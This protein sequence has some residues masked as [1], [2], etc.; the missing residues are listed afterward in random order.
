MSIK[1]QKFGNAV[2]YGVQPNTLAADVAFSIHTAVDSAFFDIKYPDFEWYNF[3]QPDQVMSDVNAGATSYAYITRDKQ[4]SAAFIGN[5]P[6]DNIP[7]VAQ[8]IGA[9]QVPVAYSAVGAQVTNEDARQY[10][11]GF[12]GNLAQ[13]LGGAMRKACDNLVESTILFGTTAVKDMNPL[14]NYPGI[15]AQTVT[16]GTWATKD[17]VAIVTD[18]NN[19]LS[20]M[21]KNS[22]TLFKPTLVFVPLDQFGL[23][24]CTPMVIGGVGLAVTILEYVIK[25]NVMTRVTGKELQIIPSRYLYNASATQGPRMIVM[26][27][28]R[29]NQCLPFPMPYTLSPPIPSPLAAIWFAE[30]KFGSYHIRQQGSVLYV[31]GI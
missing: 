19:A 15:T 30:Q 8:S 29:D 1:R 20:Y 28:S 31:D 2:S 13:D 6:N 9:V 3:V 4:G 27:R 12:N 7:M 23:L 25:N 17:P 10:Q 18:I 24:S 16:G 14:L 11:L 22:N 5:G 26:D 21:W